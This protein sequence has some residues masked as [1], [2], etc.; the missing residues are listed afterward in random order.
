VV[1]FPSLRLIG[2]SVPMLC[3][4]VRALYLGWQVLCDRQVA[5]SRHVTKQGE[6]SPWSVR[7][8]V[9]V[10][11]VG[12][13]VKKRKAGGGGRESY[14]LSLSSMVEPSGEV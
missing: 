9:S 7:R 6:L 1:A 4:S 13:V 10:K 8:K 3:P 5:L 12:R 14:C 2:V 11:S